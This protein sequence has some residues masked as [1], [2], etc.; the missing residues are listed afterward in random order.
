MLAAKHSTSSLR[1]ACILKPTVFLNLLC[2]LVPS[3]LIRQ[4]S[5]KVLSG[6]V[7][8]ETKVL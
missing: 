5:I 3:F 6:N 2:F 1:A 8:K 7:D 4:I